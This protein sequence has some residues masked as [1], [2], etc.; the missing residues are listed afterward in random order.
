MIH[1]ET[2]LVFKVTRTQL[3]IDNPLGRYLLNPT[4][5][6]GFKREDEGSLGRHVAKDSPGDALESNWQPAP[7][8]PFY[9]VLRL[10]GPKPDALEGKWT[11]PPARSAKWWSLTLCDT[12]N[13]FFNPSDWQQ[14]SGGGNG[15]MELTDA[16]GID[17]YIAA[18]ERAGVPEDNWMPIK[19]KDQD[20]DLLLRIDVPDPEKYKSYPGPTTGNFKK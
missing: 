5:I 15:G 3:F 7:D 9:M 8:G 17:V 1:S 12:Q 16:G 11:P 14:Y 6:E 4:M 20:L 10:C 13:G 18:E 19:R 2:N